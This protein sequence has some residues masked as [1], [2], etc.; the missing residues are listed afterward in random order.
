[1]QIAAIPFNNIKV[2]LSLIKDISVLVQCLCCYMHEN[3]VLRLFKLIS[4]LSLKNV[5]IFP[6]SD[7]EEPYDTLYNKL[8]QN[9]EI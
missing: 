3:N 2:F 1:M 9:N 7:E 5:K 4:D 6:E 8:Y